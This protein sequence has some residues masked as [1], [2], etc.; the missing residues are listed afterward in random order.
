[1]RKII[2][3]SLLSL[4]VLGACS[5]KDPVLPGDRVAIF[6]GTTLTYA[7]GEITNL[8]DTAFTPNVRDCPY[9][10][11][12]SNVIWHGD[13]KIFSGF[14]TSN[15]VIGNQKPVCDGNSVYAGLTTGELVRVNTKTRNIEWIADIYRAS[16]MT[17][18]AAVL[19]IIAPIIINGNDIYVGGLGDAYCKINKSNGNKKWC[20]GVGVGVPFVITDRVS[21]VLGTNNTLYAINNVDGSIYWNVTDIRTQRAPVYNNGII[22]VGSQ[23]FNATTGKI[24][25]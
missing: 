14:A 9:R 11:D 19:D 8:P 20:V 15:S 13:K 12:A 5:K 24:I 18:G 17:G 22:S 2:G 21:F 1:M 25:K 10:Q 16:N 7:S 3:L 23:K 4:L 6:P